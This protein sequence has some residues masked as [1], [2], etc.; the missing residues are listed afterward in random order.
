MGK[1]GLTGRERG[2]ELL[3]AGE[4]SGIDYKQNII[5]SKLMTSALSQICHLAAQ[6]LQV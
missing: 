4:G 2:R 5:Q 3:Q 6:S 1:S